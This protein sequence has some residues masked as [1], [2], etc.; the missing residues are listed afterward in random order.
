MSCAAIRFDDQAALHHQVDPAHPLEGDL[1]LDAQS[2]RSKGQS[3]HG[4]LTRLGSPVDQLHEAVV[5][6]REPAENIPDVGLTHEPLV[7]R[8]VE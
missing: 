3:Q 8:T 4:F 1:H 2:R 7:Q 5:F 6:L